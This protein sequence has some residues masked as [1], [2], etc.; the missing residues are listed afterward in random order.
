[1]AFSYGRHARQWESLWT[2]R[3]RRTVKKLMRKWR[4]QQLK[5]SLTVPTDQNL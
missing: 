1:M 2:M 4:R 5:R 3:Q